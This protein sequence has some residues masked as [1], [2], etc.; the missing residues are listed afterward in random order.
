MLPLP[1]VRVIAP[2]A[3]GLVLLDRFS[4][5]KIL[6]IELNKDFIIKRHSSIVIVNR[7]F[8]F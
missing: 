6:S 8:Q 4:P 1:A 2:Y 5:N 7:P 3:K